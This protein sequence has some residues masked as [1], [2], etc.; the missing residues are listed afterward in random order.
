LEHEGFVHVQGLR[1]YYRSEGDPAKGTLLVFHGGPGYTYDY[2]TPLFDLADRGYRV[3][4]FDQGGSGKSQAPKNTAWYTIENFVEEGEGVRK[5]LGLGKVHLLGFSWGGMLAQAY[6]LKYQSNLSSLILSGTTPSIPML[7]REASRLL[8]ALPARARESITK[9]EAA[10]DLT[11]PEYLAAVRMFNQRHSSRLSN[12][13]DP[14]KYS[15]EHANPDV[16]KTMFGPNAVETTGN[17][18]YWDVT[19]RLHELKVPCLIVCGEHDFLTPKLHR[20][21]HQKVRRSKLV[22]LKGAGHL[23]MWDTREAYLNALGGFLDSLQ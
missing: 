10:G 7:E 2:L 13:P 20:I 18:R 15:E 16:A 14:L 5:G 23:T 19:D 3:V 21:M 1:I 9:Y 12:T 8:Q 4:I 22:I 17:M 11:N 6:A